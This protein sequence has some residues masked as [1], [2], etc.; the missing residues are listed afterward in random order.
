MGTTPNPEEIQRVS[1]MVGTIGQQLKLQLRPVR[2]IEVDGIQMGVLSDGSAFLTL[3]G[4]AR[5]CGVEA[6]SIQRLSTNWEEER[7]K[8]RGK[9]ILELLIS[10]GHSGDSL[11]IRTAG[12]N[13][14][15]H[16]YTDAVCMAILEYYAFDASQSENRTAL[17]N[18]RLLARSSFRAFIYNRCGYDPDKHIPSSWQNFHE[19]ILTN[20]QIPVGYFSIFREIADIVIH[21]IQAG[22][23]FDDHNVPDVSVGL[24][25]GQYWSANKFDNTFG[26]RRKYPHNYPDSYPQSAIN[27]VDAWIYP[28]ASLGVFRL[29]LYREYI[30]TNFPKYL[31]NKVNQGAFLPSRAELLL[32][33]VNRPE[34]E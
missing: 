7:L 16:A 28:A 22:L 32:E 14:E 25:W 13:G 31:Q 19:R 27:P 17:N 9:R 2:E 3:R 20:D 30:P 26:D 4:L 34:L 12:S 1:A 15:T 6:S 21:M 5:V 18:Y 8:P 10:Q 23:P 11:F 29:W 24:K 33:A